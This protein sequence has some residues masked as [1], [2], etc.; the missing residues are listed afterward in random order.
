MSQIGSNRVSPPGPRLSESA[1][2]I[3]SCGIWP[4]LFRVRRRYCKVF[5]RSAPRDGAAMVLLAGSR[6]VRRFFAGDPAS[7]TLRG[8]AMLAGLLG[9]IS[10]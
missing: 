9:D 6:E 1:A 4:R 10:F 5:S 3:I 7:F 2:D 8:N